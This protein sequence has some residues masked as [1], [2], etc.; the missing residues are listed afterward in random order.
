M[1]EKNV[2]SLPQSGNPMSYSVVNSSDPNITNDS[3][4]GQKETIAIK[5]VALWLFLVGFIGLLIALGAAIA[6]FM[7]FLNTRSWD[8][9]Y[10]VAN[11]LFIIGEAIGIGFMAIMAFKIRSGLH[12]LEHYAYQS[13]FIFFLSVAIGSMVTTLITLVIT[14]QFSEAIFGMVG[15]FINGL[16]LFLLRS[17]QRLFTA[18]EI[19]S[20]IRTKT[21]IALVI[22]FL[23]LPL[24][25]Y[26]QTTAKTYTEDQLKKL[27]SEL[28]KQHQKYLDDYSKMNKPSISPTSVPTTQPTPQ[29]TP[30]YSPAG[31]NNGSLQTSGSTDY[32]RLL[33]SATDPCPVTLVNGMCNLPH[34]SYSYPNDIYTKG[35]VI[36]DKSFE[37]NGQKAGEYF[38]EC[39]G[40]NQVDEK[41]CNGGNYSEAI[42]NCAKG[43]IN[44]ACI[45]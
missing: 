19:S 21:I 22:I 16:F 8:S 34:C 27:D 37:A 41:L 13:A 32:S 40:T 1:D 28:Q 10:P 7:A 17:Q 12:K 43:C 11:T 20:S 23:F 29:A 39:K 45:K 33:T 26:V 4:S 31:T 6:G 25:L 44:G 24:G 14:K 15:V 9:F 35:K 3:T 30:I 38:D 2:A 18:E 5:I 36:L 42:Y